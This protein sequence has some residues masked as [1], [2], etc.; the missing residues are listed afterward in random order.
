MSEDLKIKMGTPEEAEWTK[1]K[2]NQEET[3]RASLINIAVSK[4]VLTLAEN[5]IIEE[6]K[7]FSAL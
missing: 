1:I 7:K 2:K 6:K 5:K 4:K 3:I